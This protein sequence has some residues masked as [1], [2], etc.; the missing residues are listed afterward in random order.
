M[1]A[2]GDDDLDLHDRLENDRM[3]ALRRFLDRHRARDLERHFAGVDVVVRAVDQLALHVDHRIARENSVL[4]RFPHSLLR[5]LD[6][7]TRDHSAD[8]LVLEHE[9]F[10]LLRRL[11]VDHHV[12]VL[13]LTTRLANELAF[14]LLDA[15][16]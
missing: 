1:Y 15:L 12:A 13:T 10:A 8:D 4:E 14:D 3:R 2:S 9:A 11:D 7:L 16:A 5:R 6:E